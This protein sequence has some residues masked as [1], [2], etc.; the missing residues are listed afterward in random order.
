LFAERL[1]L[2]GSR[3]AKTLTLVLEEG[4]EGHGGARTPF[5]EGK[6]RIVLPHVDPMPWV[7]ALP[8]LF[9]DQPFGGE[10]DDGRWNKNL[11]RFA[12]NRLLREEGAGGH[13]FLHSLAGISSGSLM[14]VQ[15]ETFRG[16]GSLDRRIFADRMT[17]VPLAREGR[18]ITLVFEEGVHMRGDVKAPFLDGRFRVFLPRADIA[19]WRAAGLPGLQEETPVGPVPEADSSTGPSSGPGLSIGDE[20]P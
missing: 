9:G 16:D 11:V 2:E 3:A 15:L 7:E 13:Y 19:R 14:E 4:Y 17:I 18:G 5:P 12:L 20:K 1:R 10:K 8:E 6:R